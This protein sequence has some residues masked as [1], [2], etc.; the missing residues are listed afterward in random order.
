MSA[1][2]EAVDV[3]QFLLSTGAATDL[4]R[5]MGT[6]FAEGLAAADP[7][8]KAAPELYDAL[9]EYVALSD[10]SLDSFERIAAEFQAET[11]CLAPGKDVAAA[12]NESDERREERHRRWR[13]WVGKRND[14]RL[15]KAKAAI[16]KADGK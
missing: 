3:V 6:A 12:V 11:G 10:V 5:A 8:A 15:A 14:A 2:H 9:R 1:A 13:E 16:V 7:K 4:A